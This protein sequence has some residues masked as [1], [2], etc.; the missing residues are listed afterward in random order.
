MAVAT[1]MGMEGQATQGQEVP[2]RI[3]GPKPAKPAVAVVTGMGMEGPATKGHEVPVRIRGQ[4]PA[5]PAVAVVTGK[6]RRNRRSTKA[7]LAAVAMTVRVRK[8]DMATK[9]NEVAQVREMP[10]TG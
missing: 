4:K 3:R 9:A 7:V 10:P 8:E 6:G 1:G 2:V 5:K